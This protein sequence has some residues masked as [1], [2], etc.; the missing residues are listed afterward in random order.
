MVISNGYS[1]LAEFKLYGSITSTNTNDDSVIEDLIESASRFIDAQTGRTFY[2]RT[3]TKYYDVPYGRELR[4]DDDLLTVTTLTNGDGTVITA[5]D[6]NLIPKNSAPYYAIKLLDTSLLR[7]QSS[8]TGGAEL[9]ISIV[10]T[11]GWVATRPDDINLACMQ[12]AKNYYNK[13]E[14]QGTEGIAK[15]TA[16]GVVVTPAGAPMSAMQ[17]INRYK[18]RT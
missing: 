18:K 3:E 2:A 14:G 16:M 6:Y 5:A 17:I 4:L 15:V 12:I 1:T 11:W 10:G 7:W 9:I 13:R 8:S